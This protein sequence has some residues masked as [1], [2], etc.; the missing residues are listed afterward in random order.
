MRHRNRKLKADGKGRQDI[1]H[2]IKLQSY[3]I[4]PKYFL[5]NI[6]NDIALRISKEEK[7]FQMLPYTHSHYI[8]K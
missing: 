2:E 8:H 4:S 5:Y 3:Q 7:H 6:V 1:V